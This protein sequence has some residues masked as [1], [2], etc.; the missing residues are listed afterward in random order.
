M[1]AASAHP[2]SSPMAWPGPPPKVVSSTAL[3]QRQTSAHM[4]VPESFF[5]LDLLAAGSPTNTNIQFFLQ[6]CCV[7]GDKQ[8]GELWM[9]I[10]GLCFYK[11]WERRVMAR[12]Q[13]ADLALATLQFSCELRGDRD[14]PLLQINGPLL[15]S[16]IIR[17]HE[18]DSAKLNRF[19][20]LG[21]VRY[22]PPPEVLELLPV[23]TLPDSFT[24]QQLVAPPNARVSTPSLA[25]RHKG[26]PSSKPRL[27][28]AASSQFNTP[29]APKSTRQQRSG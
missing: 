26:R 6:R 22:T 2:M 17:M 23:V 10:S 5:T 20:C 18:D 1:V 8:Y 28:L 7:P 14:C 25:P 19:V 11:L 15:M 21:R 3:Q 24:P 29:I 27:T 12:V 13:V 16:R 9:R 4:S